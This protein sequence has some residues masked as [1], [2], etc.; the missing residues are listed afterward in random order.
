[1]QCVF[2]EAEEG[3]NSSMTITLEDG[4]K[5]EVLICDE[6]A[7]EA[8]IKSVKAAH[9]EKQKKI[10]DLMKLAKSLGLELTSVKTQGKI[11]VP[12]LKQTSQPAPAAPPA[13]LEK[14]DFLPEEEQDLVPTSKLQ[15]V[16]G[17]TSV[18]GQTE[19]GNVAS[20]GQH[21]L[22]GLQHK[23]Q[24][25]LDGRAKMTVVEGREGMPLV[26]A[27]KQVDGLGT[28]KLRITK[29]ENDNSLQRRFKGMADAS[30]FHD[31]VPNF[32][33]AGYQNTITTCSMCSG[34]RTIRQSQ[35]GRVVDMDCPKC[36]GAGE[37][38]V[39]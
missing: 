6:H 3:L 14:L 29:K 37:V 23:L 25:S 5:V 32:A 36:N 17:M 26:L 24:G 7:E 30:V 39:Y 20:H 1:M 19:Y 27:E 38:S 31:Q 9:L 35:A 10:G 33:R 2:C 13:E 11:V 16:R 12:T 28:T 22:R 8:T 15:A 34:K 18:G 4:Q 21:D